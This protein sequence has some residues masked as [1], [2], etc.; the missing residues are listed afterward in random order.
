ML[1]A[2]H[3]GKPSPV[4][5]Q[6]VTILLGLRDWTGRPCDTIRRAVSSNHACRIKSCSKG[7]ILSELVHVC[8]IVKK[9]RLRKRV[10]SESARIGEVGPFRTESPFV[11]RASDHSNMVMTCRRDWSVIGMSPSHWL[12]CSCGRPTRVVKREPQKRSM[13]YLVYRP[14]LDGEHMRA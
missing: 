10:R 9:S 1:S 8:E 2:A 4:A 7:Y 13:R 11:R 3:R 12:A 6:D 5:V 14:C